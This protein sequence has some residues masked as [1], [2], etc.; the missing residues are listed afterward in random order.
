MGENTN[1]ER[2]V[3]YVKKAQGPRVPGSQGGTLYLDRPTCETH[4]LSGTS[5]SRGDT[6]PQPVF[7]KGARALLPLSP[8]TATTP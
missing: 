8:P 3:V 5:L 4:A 2:L 1:V 7:S 6:G